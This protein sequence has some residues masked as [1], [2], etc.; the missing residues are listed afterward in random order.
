MKESEDI[1]IEK[2]SNGFIVK[3]VYGP[4]SVPLKGDIMVFNSMSELKV[5]IE[6]HFGIYE[7]EG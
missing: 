5:F 6:L 4:G 3:G 1:V 7:Q 2:V